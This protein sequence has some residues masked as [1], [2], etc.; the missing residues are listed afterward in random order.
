M[1]NLPTQRM[2]RGQR[3]FFTD[4]EGRVLSGTLTG[5][6]AMRRGGLRLEVKWSAD[7]VDPRPPG[8]TTLERAAELQVDE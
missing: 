8:F 3:V 5:E 2:T 4:G 6:T 1:I 7:S